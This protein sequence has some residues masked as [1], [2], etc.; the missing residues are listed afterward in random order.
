M[1]VDGDKAVRLMGATNPG[2]AFVANTTVQERMSRS[3]HSAH[4]Q[5]VDVIPLI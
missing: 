2:V 4:S 3:I 5:E 1:S